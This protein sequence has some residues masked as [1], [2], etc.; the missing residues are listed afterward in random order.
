MQISLYPTMTFKIFFYFKS[1]KDD[2]YVCLIYGALLY[3]IHEKRA[4]TL[5]SNRNLGLPGKS[6]LMG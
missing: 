3:I 1:Y 6:E 4:Y 5:G 2:I